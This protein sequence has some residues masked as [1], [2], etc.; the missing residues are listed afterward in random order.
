MGVFLKIKENEGL[1]NFIKRQ[2]IDINFKW[3]RYDVAF[4]YLLSFLITNSAGA[5]HLWM[6]YYLIGA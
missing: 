5:T 6:V 3:C 2:R 4:L 1:P